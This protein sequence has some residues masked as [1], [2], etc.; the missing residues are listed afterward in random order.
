MEFATLVREADSSDFEEEVEPRLHLQHARRLGLAVMVEN[1]S[2]YALHEERHQRISPLGG[3]RRL[4]SWRKSQTKIPACPDHIKETIRKQKSCRVILLTPAFFKEGYYPTTCLESSEVPSVKVTLQAIKID[5]SQV[6]SG[7][8]IAASQRRK[9]RRLAPAGT[10]L[11]L[12]LEGED[13]DILHWIDT[14]WMRCLTESESEEPQELHDGFGLAVLGT[15]S[16]EY[17]TV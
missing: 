12:K 9:T 2:P 15:W 13:P 6:V 7:F 4:A 14:T 17:L 10:V 5:R 1:D 16:N 11:F 8:D 3:E